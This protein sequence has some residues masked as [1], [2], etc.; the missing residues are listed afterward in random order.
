M[1]LVVY[2]FL[3]SGITA[4]G[5]LAVLLR[6]IRADGGSPLFALVA[7]SAGF[8]A[9]FPAWFVEK[10]ILPYTKWYTGPAGDA[11]RAFCVA[12]FVEESIKISI[13]IVLSRSRHFRRVSDGPAL[14]LAMGL[15]FGFSENIFFSL[16]NPLTL[17]L[18]NLTSVPL[19]VLALIVP[20][21]CIGISH[22]AYKP[23]VP[24]GFCFAVLLHGSY[25]FFLLRGGAYSILSFCLLV[26]AFVLAVLLSRNARRL[27]EREGRLYQ[28]Y[29]EEN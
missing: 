23:L 20:G 10:A 6:R 2:A 25:D 26:P 16:E 8:A 3:F 18:R 1:P 19:H 22:F 12:G 24:F 11:L 14:A 9:A 7:F 13:L 4:L 27:D 21:W 15:G 28:K 29:Y 5:V 17:V